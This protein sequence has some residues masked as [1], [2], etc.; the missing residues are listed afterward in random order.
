MA[1]L[2]RRSGSEML[3]ACRHFDLMQCATGD[4]WPSAVSSHANNHCCP[5]QL[6]WNRCRNSTRNSTA[7]NMSCRY[8]PNDTQVPVDGE[9]TGSSEPH[10]GSSAM[11]GNL[12]VYASCLRCREEKDRSTEKVRLRWWCDVSIWHA[13]TS[14]ISGICYSFINLSTQSPCYMDV[15]DW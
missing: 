2:G 3:W 4:I 7:T 1:D 14:K 13:T 11:C 5:Q 8:D 12:R 10:H 15:I 6:E 9:R